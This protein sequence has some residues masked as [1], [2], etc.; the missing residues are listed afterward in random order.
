MNFRVHAVIERQGCALIPSIRFRQ[1]LKH[2]SK[3]WL[4]FISGRIAKRANEEILE[5]KLP[6]HQS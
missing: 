5:S 4:Y 3:I 1:D 2:E 6:L